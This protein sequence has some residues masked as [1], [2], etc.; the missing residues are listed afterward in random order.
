MLDHSNE[1]I[2]IPDTIYDKESY[3]RMILT[4]SK[5]AIPSMIA[6]TMSLS[7]EIVNIFFIGHLNDSAKIA[8]VGLGNMYANIT[9]F[10]FLLGLN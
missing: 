6:M 10:S 9:C 2:T 3:F 1:S 7:M 4:F 5:L 8:G